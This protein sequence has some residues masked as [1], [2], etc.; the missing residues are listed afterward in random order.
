MNGNNASRAYWAPILFLAAAGFLLGGPFVNAQNVQHLTIT[1]P[2]GMPGLPVL[3]G[4]TRVTNGIMLTWDGPSGYYQVFERSNSF[5]GSWMALGKAT[6]LLRFAVVPQIYSNAFF[7]VSGPAP[8]YIGAQACAGCHD[9][10][11]ATELNTPHAGAFT[12]ADF[13]AAGGQTN[14][15]CLACHT[16]GYGL[17]TGF[18]SQSKTPQLANVQCENCHG[19]AGNH[20]ANSGRSDRRPAG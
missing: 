5:Y 19:P 18:V 7:R 8:A 3:T 12:N 14:S 13:V 10:I 2:G 16:V 1:Q 20:A 9:S 15:S 4:I 11:R 6:N 17:P